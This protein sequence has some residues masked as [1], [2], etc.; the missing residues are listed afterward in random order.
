M[1]HIWTEPE[2]RP[3]KSHRTAAKLGHLPPPVPPRKEGKITVRTVSQAWSLYASRSSY[4][5]VSSLLENSTGEGPVPLSRLAPTQES[6]LCSKHRRARG[7]ELRRGLGQTCK[8]A[9]KTDGGGRGAEV[10]QCTTRSSLLGLHQRR[11]LAVN[12]LLGRKRAEGLPPTPCGC[13][14]MGSELQPTPRASAPFQVRHPDRSPSRQCSRPSPGPTQN[15]SMWSGPS[16]M[17]P[18][19]AGVC[20]PKRLQGREKSV[21]EKPKMRGYRTV[22]KLGQVER[23]TGPALDKSEMGRPSS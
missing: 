6:P 10:V 7:T 13:P 8:R 15:K 9:Q 4:W 17:N 23:H 12:L 1:A 18:W 3:S 22:V 21:M 16:A 2:G 5:D 19:Q 14:G 20:P 11:R